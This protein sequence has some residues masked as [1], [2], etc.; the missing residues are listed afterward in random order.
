MKYDPA[1]YWADRFRQHGL[2]MRGCG[3][4]GYTDEQSLEQYETA[5]GVLGRAIADTGAGLQHVLEVG[6]GNGWWTR[7][8][9]DAG[10]KHY[11]GMDITDVLFEHH[12][13]AF[14]DWRFVQGD[15]TQTRPPGR[16]HTLAL[17]LDVTQHIIAD[18]DLG[19]ALGHVGD[20]VRPGGVVLVTAWGHTR[21]Y[22]SYEQ[23]HSFE[24]YTS[25]FPGWAQ[26]GP[27]R[28]RDK[29]L[30]GFVKKGGKQK[31]NAND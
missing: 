10:A 27:E 1:Q 6:V 26:W 19:R 11:T 21:R 7:W 20:A 25:R 4:C 16:G 30:V 3:C 29:H 23:A 5:T 12:H 14:P 28:Y 24:A 31:G 17:L 22:R 8:L 9:R 2:S 15:I 13:A 18:A